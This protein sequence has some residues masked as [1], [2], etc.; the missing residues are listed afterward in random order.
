MQTDR[1]KSNVMGGKRYAIGLSTERLYR[2][3]SQS[4][5]RP[6]KEVRFVRQI[7]GDGAQAPKT[8]ADNQT[9]W[10][11]WVVAV[12]PWGVSKIYGV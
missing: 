12:P 2:Y 5:K 3:E 6:V 9:S 4:N 7:D 11:V 8:G 1:L 10:A